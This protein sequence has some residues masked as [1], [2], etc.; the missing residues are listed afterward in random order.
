MT[1]PERARRWQLPTCPNGQ[2]ADAALTANGYLELPNAAT[3]TPP[4]L[5]TQILRRWSWRCGHQRQI[6][7]WLRRSDPQR[8]ARTGRMKHSALRQYSHA[9]S[10]IPELFPIERMGAIAVQDCL[11]LELQ[12][13]PPF[14]RSLFLT[15]GREAHPQ[16]AIQ[17]TP[18]TPC[19]GERQII[20]KARQATLNARGCVR[21]HSPLHF[22]L[23]CLPKDRAPKHNLSQKPAVL[24]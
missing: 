23:R 18:H 9:I 24:R 19:G 3:A 21:R 16:T 10:I 8:R 20:A 15:L 7:C 13:V 2:C 1:L 22:G 6:N 5:P 12:Q 11:G 4:P 14:A 17:R